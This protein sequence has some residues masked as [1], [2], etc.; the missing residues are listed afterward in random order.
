MDKV[1]FSQNR[2]NQKIGYSPEELRIIQKYA[3]KICLQSICDKLNEVS[4]THRTPDRV[5]NK[6]N[7]MGYSVVVKQ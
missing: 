7:S 1:S 6:V 4:R 5:R 3:G 2:R